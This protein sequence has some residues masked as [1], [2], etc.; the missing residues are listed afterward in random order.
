MGNTGGKWMV[1]LQMILEVFSNLYD[2]TMSVKISELEQ[3]SFTEKKIV[4]RTNRW[5]EQT[6][7]KSVAWLPTGSLMQFLWVREAEKISCLQDIY[8]IH[9]S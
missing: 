3:F 7:G 2:S 9:L 5:Q 1:G 4:Y 6:W 8:L